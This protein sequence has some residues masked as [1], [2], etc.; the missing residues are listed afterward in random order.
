MSTIKFNNGV[1]AE[2]ENIREIVIMDVQDLQKHYAQL[3]AAEIE[4]GGANASV[5]GK[6]FNDCNA[7][8]DLLAG[9]KAA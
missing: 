2:A 8:I 6:M 5:Y 3:F 7:I 4:A 9:L 1:N